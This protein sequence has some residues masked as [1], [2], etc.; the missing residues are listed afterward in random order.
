MALDFPT[1]PT[2]GQHFP[3]TP[4]A[5]IPTYTWD[6]E[7]WST[8]GG[9]VSGGSSVCYDIAQALTPAQQ[10]QARQNIYAAPFSAMAYSGMQVNGSM[11]VSQELGGS[12]TGTNAKYVLDGWVLSFGGTMGQ[13]GYQGATAVPGFTNSIFNN[14][15]TAQPTLGSNDYALINQSIEGY[16]IARLAWGTANAQPITIAF[17]CMH[18]IP[19]TYSGIVRDS[20]ADTCYAFTYTHNVASAWEYKTITIPGPTTGTWKTD[21]TVGL[22]VYL[23]TA[24]GNALI[25]PSA[26]AWLSGNYVAA[27]GQVNG[28]ATAGQLNAYTGFIMVPGNEAPSAARSPFVMRSYDQ[29]LPLCNRYWQQCRAVIDGVATTA[30]Q[31]VTT[32]ITF[33]PKMRAAP[34]AITFTQDFAPGNA[35]APT[36]GNVSTY[37]CYFQMIAPAAGRSY[38][39]GSVIADA[40]L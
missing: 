9:S 16:R 37:G 31:I 7:K 25:A 6:G 33:A 3:A 24:S 10:Q 8:V 18:T 2:N 11:D 21:N 29:E 35:S 28:V 12:G 15:N 38:Y 22:V 20:A 14:N 30:G 4:L 1:S 23:T 26:N 36:T 13:I 5:G 17:W 39:Y 40:R 27:P 19:G 32:G 34:T